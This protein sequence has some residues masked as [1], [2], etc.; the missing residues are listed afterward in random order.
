M[1]T[2][3]T[4]RKLAAMGI[5]S[6]TDFEHNDSEIEEETL[7]TI[8]PLVKIA[9]HSSNDSGE[10]PEQVNETRNVCLPCVSLVSGVFFLVGSVSWVGG[11]FLGY[12]VCFLVGIVFLGWVVCFLGR[13]CVSW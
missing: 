9:S 5:D 12:V 6:S 1:T 13:R 11:L 2:S 7:P 8:A 10:R 4:E 3:E